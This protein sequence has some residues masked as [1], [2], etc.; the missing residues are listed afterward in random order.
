MKNKRIWLTGASRGIG[1][2]TAKLLAKTEADLFLSA[3]SEQSFK[4]VISDFA[5]HKNTYLMPCD[6]SSSLEIATIYK[7]IKE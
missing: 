2:E 3:R 7:K 1:L 6:V 4:E 5:N